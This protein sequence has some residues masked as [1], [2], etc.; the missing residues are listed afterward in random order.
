REPSALRGVLTLIP[1]RPMPVIRTILLFLFS[2]L[3]VAA[4]PVSRLKSFDLDAM[5]RSVDACEDFYRYACA[6]WQKANPIPPDQTRWGRFDVLREYN[7]ALLPP[8]LEKVAA[9][10]SYRH[11]DEQKIADYYATC[12]DDVGADR[13]GLEPAWP[14]LK[15]FDEMKTTSDLVP[16]IADLHQQRVN[17]LFAFGSSPKL[18]DAANVGAWAD[19]GGLGLPN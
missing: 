10:T 18:H 9:K 12:M 11:A 16:V 7:R 6:G 5:D 14:W 2:T 15:K 3:A 13:K 1:E 17:A 19:Q 8:L 4:D